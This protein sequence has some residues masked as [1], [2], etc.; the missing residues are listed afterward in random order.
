MSQN[1]VRKSQNV[2]ER[3]NTSEDFFPA[4]FVANA[5]GINR[6]SFNDWILSGKVK[7]KKINGS[8]SFQRMKP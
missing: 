5:L 7:S 2:A 4:T 1:I 8:I 3:D 6:R